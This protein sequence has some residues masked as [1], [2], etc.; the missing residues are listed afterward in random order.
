MDL[1]RGFPVSLVGVIQ[2]NCQQEGEK[3]YEDGD[4]VGVHYNVATSILVSQR[5]L[6]DQ[7]QSSAEQS[8]QKGSERG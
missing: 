3:R 4:N 5:V 7:E 6:V 1:C 8:W 2:P